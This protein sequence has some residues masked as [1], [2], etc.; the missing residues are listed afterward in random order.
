MTAGAPPMSSADRPAT[1]LATRLT[2]LAAGFGLACWAPLVPLVKERLR[3]DDAVLGVLILCG[4][5]GAVTAMLLAGMLS[6]RFG[7]RPILRAGGLALAGVLPLLALAGTPLA[8]GLTLLAFG[9]CLGFVDVAMN[10]Q[11]VE[12]ERAADEPLMSG[13][14]A[15]FSLGSLAGAAL[16]TFLLSVHL[17]VL[18]SAL[19]CSALILT[20]VSVAWPRLL[21]TA[22][23][24]S[25]PLF[26]VPRGIV[27]GLAALT[28]VAFL[29]EGAML[30]WSALLLS[31]SG[32]VPAV[33]SGIGYVVFSVAM[34]AGRLGGDAVT[35]RVGDRA[36]LFWGSLVEIAGFVV[37]LATRIPSVAMAG[38]LLI[39]LGASNLVPVLF[40]RGGSQQAMPSGLAITAIITGGYAG[41][42]LGPSSIGFVAKTVG[43]PAAFWM[44]AGL[45]CVVP[46]SARFVA[47]VR[48]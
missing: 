40:R 14:H 45:I 21:R 4:G 2:F 24:E 30:D 41:V 10:A 5:A 8:L 16:M 48:G 25:G 7:S 1:R 47:P 36:T 42:L 34:I 9:G 12:V 46:L 27:L 17:G 43:L 23:A 15:H 38:C 22:R 37:L 20:S 19:I 26:V 31:G 6:A 35:A 33:H 29:T 32:V 3:V 44:L 13:F 28:G 39:G 18:P 11:A